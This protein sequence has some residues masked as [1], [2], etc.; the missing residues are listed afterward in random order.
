AYDYH[1][2]SNLWIWGTASGR[3]IFTW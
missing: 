1:P 2:R 3:M